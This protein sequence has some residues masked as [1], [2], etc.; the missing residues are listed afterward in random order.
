MEDLIVRVPSADALFVA[1]MMEK[2]GYS[3]R[4]KH[5]QGT[6]KIGFRELFAKAR[7]E[8]GVDH[9]WTLDEINAEISEV[10]ANHAN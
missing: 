9:E 3:V 4:N 7:E 5:L 8:A 2:M 6:K 1:Q 10:R